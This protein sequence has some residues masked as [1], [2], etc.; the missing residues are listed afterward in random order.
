MKTARNLIAKS[1]GEP[2]QSAA[3]PRPGSSDHLRLV[4]A[5]I[6]GTPEVGRGHDRSSEVSRGQ[7]ITLEV[8]R[9]QAKQQRLVEDMTEL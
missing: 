2:I 7:D 8:R 9:G 3:S 6:L 1:G 5:R 4:E